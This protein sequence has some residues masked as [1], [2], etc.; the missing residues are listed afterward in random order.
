VGSSHIKP[1]CHRRAS[2]RRPRARLCL[3][4]GCGRKYQP[5]CWHQRYCQ[6]VECQRQ[7]GRRLHARAKA[8]HAEAQRVRRR[9]AEAV[10]QTPRNCE[11]A[12][13]RGHAIGIF[14]TPLC[15]RPGCQER[16]LNSIRNPARYC[17]AACRQAVGNVLDRE[18][19]SRSR[20][21]LPGR[22]KRASEYQAARVQRSRHQHDPS[23]PTPSPAS[24]Q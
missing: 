4:K 10:P 24:P 16:P 23:G 3:R 7:A 2:G 12:A 18:R 19:K 1:K 17:C 20:G 21:T 5:R 22:R 14:S 13:A 6:D 15:A 11:V 9:R 8:Q